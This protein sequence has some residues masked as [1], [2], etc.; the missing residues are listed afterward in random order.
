MKCRRNVLGHCCLLGERPTLLFESRRI[1]RQQ[2][3]RL[4]LDRR[5]GKVV[6][7]LLEVANILAEL[8][9]LV[10]VS[11]RVVKGALSDSNHL[12][13]DTYPSLVQNL[14]SDL[15]PHQQSFQVDPIKM[16]ATHF[17]ALADL[18][19]DILLGNLDIIEIEDASGR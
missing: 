9:A 18:A 19:D 17:V 14:D 16:S 8:L 1:V 5:L 15:Q 2:P 6:T 10:G 13:S 3:R 4:D 12:C 7:H 11:N